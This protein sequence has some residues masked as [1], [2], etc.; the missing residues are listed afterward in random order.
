MFTDSFATNQHGW[1]TGQAGNYTYELADSAY[2]IRRTGPRSLASARSYLQLPD[3]LNLNRATS[4]LIEA[5][6]IAPKGT[7][8]EGGLMLGA[9]DD[10]NYTLI[11]LTGPTA[12]MLTRVVDGVSRSTILSRHRTVTDRTLVADSGR[13]RLQVEKR[14]GK[15]FV[16][17]NGHELSGKPLLFSSFQGNGIGFVSSADTVTFQHLRVRVSR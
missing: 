6:M 9:S 4:F 12:C 13:N 7:V 16:S 10:T 8:P 11:V 3:S 2:T 5:D 15:L 14:N 17:V 1:Q